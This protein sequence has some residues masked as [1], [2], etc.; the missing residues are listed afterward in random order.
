[1]A[2]H[3]QLAG[4]DPQWWEEPALRSKL[5]EHDTSAVFTRLQAHGWSQTAIGSAIG[6]AQNEVSLIRSGSRRVVSYD[7]LSRIAAAFGI[8]AGY[9][10]VAWSEAPEP[11]ETSDALAPELRSELLGVEA[12]L[13]VGA[14]VKDI[15]QWLAKPP[16]AKAGKP[17]RV[18][19]AD[20]ERLRDLTQTLWSV[21]NE[22]GGGAA[23]D[24]AA[25]TLSAATALM[26]AEV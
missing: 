20:V 18:G 19:S 5:A 15:D 6:L 21:D 25:G 23:L 4:V 22:F 2:E 17:A 3:A 11:E 14:T 24:P 8:P 13:T 16:R 9:M 26:D 7:L 1:M 12:A 10:G